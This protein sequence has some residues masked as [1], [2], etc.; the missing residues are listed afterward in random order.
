MSDTS[1]QGK[2]CLVTGA[3][4][5]IGKETVRALADRGAT[6]VIVGRNPARVQATIREIKT[7]TGNQNVTGLIGDLSEQAD[8][9]RVAAEFQAQHDRL[10]V[11]INNAGM[12]FW[13]REVTPDGL[14]HTFAL[15][16]MAYFL[17]VQLLLPTLKASAPARIINVASE[18]HRGARLDFADL[19]GERSYSAM[20]AYG[21][22]K[23][24]NIMF[25]YELARRLAGTGVTANTLHPGFVASGFARNNGAVI[26][27]ILDTLL[28]PMQI[29]TTKG[30]QTSIYLATS[31]DVEGVTGKYFDKSKP[32]TSNDASYNQADQ[33]RLWEI[34]ESL[35]KHEVPATAPAS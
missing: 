32:A 21:Q 31:P 20:R 33:Q 28:R 19:Q 29:N 18:A 11:L 1:M 14:E 16:H 15:N 27:I 24:A 10:H 7:Q 23:L 9:R 13:R 12:L 30:A 35:I 17:L 34:S 5:G 22:S 6:V 4:N 2:I 25:T 26:R 3:T 8:V